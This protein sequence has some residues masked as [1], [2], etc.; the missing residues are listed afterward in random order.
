MLGRLATAVGV[1]PKIY[2]HYDGELGPD[3][4]FVW[5]QERGSPF[6]KR[7]LSNA[8]SAFVR[9]YESKHGREAFAGGMVR[10]VCCCK[11]CA[12]ALLLLLLLIM[13]ISQ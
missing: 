12:L 8:L 10:Y 9:S 7:S 4:T 13:L 5:Q 2:L 1:M 11:A 3:H 6:T